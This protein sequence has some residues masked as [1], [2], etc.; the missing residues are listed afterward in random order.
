[1][2]TFHGEPITSPSG[3]PTDRAPHMGSYVRTGTQWGKRGAHIVVA[4]Q[5]FFL[6]TVLDDDLTPE[7]VTAHVDWL[8]DML[9]I[10]FDT[11]V[12]LEIKRRS[13]S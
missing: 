5:S 12:E 8:R 7:Q 6:P 1:M 4:S 2:S 11:M 10:A 3:R 13:A 9:C